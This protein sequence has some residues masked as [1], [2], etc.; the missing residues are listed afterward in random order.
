MRSE[1]PVLVDF[2]GEGCG[3]CRDLAPT[4]DTAQE[5]AGRVKVG[6]LDVHSNGKTGMRYN[7]RAIP[8][9]LLFKS[10]HVV[11]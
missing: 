6:K 9:L 7:I 4:I 2:W 8:T 3:P 10:G 5:Y 1:I 11:E